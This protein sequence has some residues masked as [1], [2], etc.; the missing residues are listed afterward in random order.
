MS[1]NRKKLYKRNEP[2]DPF[3]FM[4]PHPYTDPF[5][6]GASIAQMQ[7]A[8]PMDDDYSS[9]TNSEE[10]LPKSTRGRSNRKQAELR[11]RSKPKPPPKAKTAKQPKKGPVNFTTKSG[12]QV[13]FNPTGKR[14]AKKGKAPKVEQ[15]PEPVPTQAEHEEMMILTDEE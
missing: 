5:V 10:E 9:E 11:P 8:P 14:A 2:A 1:K 15:N 6:L 7:M 3:W 12:K 4:R 13:S